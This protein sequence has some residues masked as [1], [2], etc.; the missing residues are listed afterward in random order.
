MTV[1]ACIGLY[2]V[3][4]ISFN[5]VCPKALQSL[6]FRVDAYFYRADIH[7]GQAIWYGIWHALVG[8]YLVVTE[9]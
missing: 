7:R 5:E 3:C 6:F 9:R 4:P 2:D 1:S 8:R